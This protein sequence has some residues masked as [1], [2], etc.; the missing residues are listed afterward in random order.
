MQY[1]QKHAIIVLLVNPP[2]SHYATAIQRSVELVRLDHVC[3]RNI[4][5]V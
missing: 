5:R 2:L 3:S 4:R 1:V